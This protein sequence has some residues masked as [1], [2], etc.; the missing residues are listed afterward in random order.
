[1]LYRYKRKCKHLGQV[2]K[3]KSNFKW[4]KKRV[5][6]KKA[7]PMLKSIHKVN[8]KVQLEVPGQWQVDYSM[9]REGGREREELGI[10]TT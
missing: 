4:K 5:R 2:L 9:E 6:G 10:I 8:I 3:D 1:M 7:R